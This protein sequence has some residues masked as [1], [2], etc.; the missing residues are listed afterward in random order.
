MT[1]AIN[2]DPSC[3]MMQK[4][5]YKSCMFLSNHRNHSFKQGDVCTNVSE[6]K[7]PQVFLLHNIPLVTKCRTH[8]S[9]A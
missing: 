5:T 7:N 4:A 1:G 9:V 8:K 3:K 6:Q 2:F